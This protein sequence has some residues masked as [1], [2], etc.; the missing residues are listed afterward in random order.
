MSLWLMNAG[1]MLMVLLSVLPVGILQSRAS[2]EVGTW[3][4]RSAE[5]VHGP[6][7]NP[8]RWLRIPGDSLF[9]MGALI[10]G[11]FVLGP[12]FGWSLERKLRVEQGSTEV[13]AI[14]GEPASAE[15]EA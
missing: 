11:W 14:G 12:R 7:M 2:V 8:L 10:L 3:W 4:A 9:A 1:L 15:R 5:S 6:H 13:M